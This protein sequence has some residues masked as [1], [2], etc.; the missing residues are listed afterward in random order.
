MEWISDFIGS[1][2]GLVVLAVVE[3]AYMSAGVWYGFDNYPF[4]FLTLVLSL[5]ALQFSQII[6]VVQN[7]QGQLIEEKADLERHEVSADLL[8][9][10][11]SLSI[12]RELRDRLT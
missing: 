9:D 12:L 1:L 8:A 2:R 7:R 11:E 5:I 4:P 10:M 6:I 3:V